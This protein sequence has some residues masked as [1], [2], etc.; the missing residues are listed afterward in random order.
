[1]RLHPALLVPVTVIAL[2]ACDQA[3]APRL[4]SLGGTVSTGGGT[5]NN[6]ST[7]AISPNRV[8]LVVGQTFQLSTN[9]SAAQQNQVAWS[10]LQP[11]IA[12]VSPSGLVT[13]LSAGT[14]TV[15][16]RLSSDT[17]QVATATVTVTP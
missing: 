10:S 16:A 11:T 5:S 15:V 9:A 8:L 1:M 3:T 7:L 4:A 2:A 14:A 12:A 17:N 13:A 6:S